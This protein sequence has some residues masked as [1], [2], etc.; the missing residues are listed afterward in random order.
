MNIHVTFNVIQKQ[1]NKQSVTQITY[2][3]RRGNRTEK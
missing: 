3:M 1:T 2:K